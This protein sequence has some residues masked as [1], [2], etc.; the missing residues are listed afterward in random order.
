MNLKNKIGL[1]LLSGSFLAAIA[2][3]AAAQVNGV[4]QRGYVPQNTNG[5]A[6]AQYTPVA[7]QN[8]AADQRGDRRD[9]RWNNNDNRRD[10]RWDRRDNRRDQRWD[11]RD[12]RRDHR[13][14]RNDNRRHDNWNRNNNRYY[15]NNHN[16][17]YG[18][19]NYRRDNYR[20][21]YRPRYSWNPSRRVVYAPNF[22]YPN[23]R[24]RY[25]VGARFYNYNNYRINDYQ[26][27]GLYQPP[28]GYHWVRHDNDAYLAA[29]G[30]GLVAG[31]IIGALAGGY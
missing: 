28:R 31:I 3:P 17:Y 15:G 24:P 21:N 16:Q 26:R 19:N 1:A 9:R 2:L 6:T 5:Y 18:H 10:H 14:D 12:T 8:R 29:A 11:R 22:Y 25:S 7:A 4:N 13:W 20:Q 27:W 23:Y 30:T